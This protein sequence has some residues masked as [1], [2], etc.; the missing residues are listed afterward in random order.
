MTKLPK[1]ITEFAFHIQAL[2]PSCSAPMHF[3]PGSYGE[4]VVPPVKQCWCPREGCSEYQRHWWLD[5]VTGIAQ[6]QEESAHQ[7][8]WVVDE[9]G[10]ILTSY[11]P[12]RPVKCECGASAYKRDGD[13]LIIRLKEKR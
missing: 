12:Y 10:A 1:G 11:P 7:H 8:Q 6:R 9:H 13:G 2:C 4:D 5:L 3:A